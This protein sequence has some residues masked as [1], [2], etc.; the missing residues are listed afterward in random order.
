MLGNS[1]RGLNPIQK[2][3]LYRCCTL[4]IV[5]YRFQLWYYNKVPLTYPLEKLKKMQR[6]AAIW[7]TGA[8]RTSPTA[9]IKAIAG[10]IPIHLHLQKLYGCV[11]LWAHSLLQNH[12]I[13]SLLEP[14]NPNSQEPHWLSLDN[15]MPKQWSSIKGPIVDMDNKFNKVFPSFSPFNHE[16]SPGNRL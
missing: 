13:N 6:R 2:R 12:I 7:I 1:L 4:P 11:L 3:H 15:L 10:L 16:F 8:F 9:G 14:R 5:L